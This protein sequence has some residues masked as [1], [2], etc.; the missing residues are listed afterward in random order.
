MSPVRQKGASIDTDGSIP[1]FTGDVYQPLF[2]DWKTQGQIA[3]QTTYPLPLNLLAIIS[4][5]EVG[6]DAGIGR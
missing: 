2:K 6:D 3:V 1:L 4:G 5:F